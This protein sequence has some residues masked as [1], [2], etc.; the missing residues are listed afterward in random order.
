MTSK[1]IAKWVEN[2]CGDSFVKGISLNRAKGY[3]VVI[4][5]TDNGEEEVK[6]SYPR[7]ELTK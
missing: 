6:I 3:A 2:H 1:E 4:V 5:K 7:E